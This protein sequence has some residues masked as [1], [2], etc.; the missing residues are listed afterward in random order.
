[1]TCTYTCMLYIQITHIHEYIVLYKL[2]NFKYHLGLNFDHD[3]GLLYMWFHSNNLNLC[4]YIYIYI[5][6]VSTHNLI[7]I[8]HPILLQLCVLAFCII[9]SH[10]LAM[11]SL[12][13][14]SMSYYRCIITL[15]QKWHFLYIHTYVYTL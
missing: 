2:L 12:Y 9:T 6:I 1:M 15:D 7:S 5:A 13:T 3:T 14:C 8:L 10:K 11:D 4:V